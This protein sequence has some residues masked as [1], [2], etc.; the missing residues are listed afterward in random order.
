M[1][2][3]YLNLFYLTI[4]LLQE[5]LDQ[6]VSAPPSPREINNGDTASNLVQHIDSLRSEVARLKDQLRNAQIERGLQL[7]TFSGIYFYTVNVYLEIIFF[8]P[9]KS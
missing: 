3:D 7:F 6:P 4:R 8:L 1:R 5:K 2:V 9:V